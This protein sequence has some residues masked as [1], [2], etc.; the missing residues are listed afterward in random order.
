MHTHPSHHHNTPQLAPHL[1]VPQDFEVECVA[2][3][4]HA[5]EVVVLDAL[6]IPVI[7]LLYVLL[8]N[9]KYNGDVDC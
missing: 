6:V 9:S 5:D 1:S 7:F 8:D 4:L 2:H 3:V